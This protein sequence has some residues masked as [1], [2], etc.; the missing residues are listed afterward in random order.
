[1][2]DLGVLSAATGASF[3]LFLGVLLLPG[4][5][6]QR[7]STGLIACSVAST[8]WLGALACYSVNASFPLAVP[9]FLEVL[10]DALLFCFLAAI[11]ARNGTSPRVARLIL[12]LVF[13][14]CAALL[15]YIP[16]DAWLPG[17]INRTFLGVDLLF[18]GH[19][20]LAILGL[21]LV[22][23]LFRYTRAESRWAIKFLYI[24]LGGLFAYDLYLYSNA[25]L[26]NRI[27]AHI[28]DARGAVNAL[29]V[30]F[31]A[32]AAARN[33]HWKFDLFVSRQVIFHST[34]LL[35]TGV[36]LLL[37]AG[38][39]YYIKHYGGT[40]GGVL[41]SYFFAGALVVLL[42][43]MFSAQLRARLKVFLAKHFYR[44]K[45]DY[46]EEWLKFTHTL[47]HYEGSSQLRGAAVRAMAQIIDSPGGTL[48]LCDDSDSY[49][50]VAGWNINNGDNTAV[51][52]SSSLI[53]F[54]GKTGWIID[55]REHR[56]HPD[57]Y[58]NL[59][60]P[61]GLSELQEAWLIVP[62]IQGECVLGF[63]VLKQSLACD[64][65]DW[66]DSDLLK[67][68]G[69]QSASYLALLHATDALAQARQFEAFNRLSAFVV[70]DL[71][72]L[73][74]QLSLVV[75]NAK[76]HIHN[77][78][79]M[80]DAVNTVENAVAKLNRLLQHLRKGAL[81][82]V[83]PALLDLDR[84][85]EEVVRA[86]RGMRPAPILEVQDQGL[87]VFAGHQWLQT[88]LEH[89][90][91]N[92][93]EATPE[94]GQLTVRLKRHGEMARIEIEDTG[95]GMDAAFI[96]NRLFAPFDTTKGNAGMGIGVFESREIVR[97]L[98]GEIQVTSR[99]NLGTTFRITLPLGAYPEAVSR[100]DRTPESKNERKKPQAQEAARGRR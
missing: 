33:P 25:L 49:V 57:R 30:P 82:D 22:E 61:R 51:P 45:Y 34:A 99:P 52:A 78:E 1:M 2:I 44:N 69:R 97:S 20:A 46:R 28:W 81:S 43:L 24:G 36:Y 54:L 4:W 68:V 26:A 19:L 64:T 29:A 47:S 93:Q 80:E 3:Y 88:A 85:L 91:Q 77:Q 48:W 40:W 58:E 39:G 15:I 31:L 76:R 41:Q 50:R 67:T 23:D 35:G 38:A 56:S 5:Q 70:H 98:G 71:K 86:R 27:D 10:R 55:L 18:F 16:L 7:L 12:V 8:L 32:V 92:A 11:L 90:V 72:N 79:F 100:I 87:R 17:S 13:T 53:E 66:E 62:L 59:E 83:Q 75:S 96:R 63:I 74:A 9:R 14:L 21:V 84:L 6:G 37:M 95:C 94:H 60:I 73:V 89:I 65:I 42:T